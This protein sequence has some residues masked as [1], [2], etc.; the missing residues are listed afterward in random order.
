MKPKQKAKEFVN[1]MMNFTDWHWEDAK[2][3]SLIL[4]SELI[5]ENLRYDYIPFEGSRSEYFLNVEKEIQ[6]L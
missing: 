6:K 3:C 1:K 5:K 4:V 2:N